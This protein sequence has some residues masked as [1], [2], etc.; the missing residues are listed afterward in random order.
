M[1]LV[2]KPPA[3]KHQAVVQHAPD[4][5]YNYTCR[6]T[7]TRHTLQLHLSYAGLQLHQH[8]LSILSLR[9]FRSFGNAID[10]DAPVGMTG[11]TT[12][13]RHAPVMLRARRGCSRAIDTPGAVWN[14]ITRSRGVQRAPDMRTSYAVKRARAMRQRRCFAREAMLLRLL[15][16]R[17]GCNRCDDC[18]L[19]R[20]VPPARARPAAV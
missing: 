14:R 5:H 16:C 3:R 2:R 8:K 4:I 18:L 6:T 13:T 1:E 10:Q 15:C 12:P 17:P 7:C 9:T 20:A 19:G 11:P